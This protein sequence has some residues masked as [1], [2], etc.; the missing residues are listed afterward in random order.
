M[1]THVVSIT[2]KDTNSAEH[3]KQAVPPQPA[4]GTEDP[5]SATDHVPTTANIDPQGLT[6]QLERGTSSRTSQLHQ[7]PNPGSR[8]QLS[9]ETTPMKVDRTRT[10][11]LPCRALLAFAVLAFT[12][13]STSLAQ[14]DTAA[15]PSRID[16]HVNWSTAI[17]SKPA[18]ESWASLIDQYCKR[19][20]TA[21][22]FVRRLEL[23]PATDVSS[24]SIRFAP[25]STETAPDFTAVFNGRFSKA[26][27]DDNLPRL[28]KAQF[29]VETTAKEANGESYFEVKSADVPLFFGCRNDS[30]FWIS[31]DETY[32]TRRAETD[33]RSE[34]GS[35]ESLSEADANAL[36][37]PEPTD[38]IWISANAAAGQTMLES[39]G[40]RPTESNVQEVRAN[41]TLD[42]GIK[43]RV[44]IK[45]LSKLDR[46][47]LIDFADV[48]LANL[49]DIFLNPQVAVAFLA[50]VVYASESIGVDLG[51]FLEIDESGEP[52]N[53]FFSDA[54]F[55]TSSD[56]ELVEVIATFPWTRSIGIK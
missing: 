19:N 52:I 50:P 37:R 47:N 41:L 46:D 38:L 7:R 55:R 15:P 30:E 31:S 34:G 10:S 44:V 36:A 29:E 27:M 43:I 28:L 6:Q 51:E 16:V 11:C 12:T 18:S 20:A 42:R 54:T 2:R 56:N 35:P 14:S 23:N 39:Y 17:G 4:V 13:V 33:S 26:A 5:S 53:R 21:S 48:S 45:G 9:K 3:R 32:A 25:A 24:F 22:L 1:S 40:F 49:K 8:I